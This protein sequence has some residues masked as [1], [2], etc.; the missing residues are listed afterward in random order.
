MPKKAIVTIVNIFG[1]RVGL[2]TDLF[3][4]WPTDGYV[5]GLRANYPLGNVKRSNVK[6]NSTNGSLL[7]LCDNDVYTSYCFEPCDTYKDEWS[8]CDTDGVNGSNIKTW[9]EDILRD[10]NTFDPV[11]DDELERNDVIYELQYNRN[12]FID[13]PE[14]VDQISDF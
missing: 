8:C 1:Q 10:W 4:L 14:W 12:P 3:E 5:N 6:Y 9:M 11:D 13:Y 7:G 2:E